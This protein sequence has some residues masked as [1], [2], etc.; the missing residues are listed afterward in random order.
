MARISADIYSSVSIYICN[1]VAQ[2]ETI[3]LRSEQSVGLIILPGGAGLIVSQPLK[4]RSENYN[5]AWRLIC[6]V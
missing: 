5:K 1:S 6:W 3:F 4:G 2:A